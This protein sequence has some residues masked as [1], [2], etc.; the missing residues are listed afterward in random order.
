MPLASPLWCGCPCMSPLHKKDINL[1]RLVSKNLSKLMATV[2]MYD[3]LFVLSFERPVRSAQVKCTTTTKLSR[4]HSNL[5]VV[6]WRQQQELSSATQASQP[7]QHSTAACQRED[8][9]AEK[10]ETQARYCKKVIHLLR[11]TFHVPKAVVLAGTPSL[12]CDSPPLITA[13]FALTRDS[14]DTLISPVHLP[15]HTSSTIN[16]QHTLLLAGAA[17]HFAFALT[18]LHA[19]QLMARHRL[20]P[21]LLLP[22]TTATVAPITN[23]PGPPPCCKCHSHRLT[24]TTSHLFHLSATMLEPTERSG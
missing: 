12:M 20:P 13:V 3:F 11:L 14:W 17:Q 6:S 19:P 24:T 23:I 10:N 7:R 4:D 5:R 18:S 2:L 22:Y 16:H 8:L 15:C 9:H 21:L 1:K